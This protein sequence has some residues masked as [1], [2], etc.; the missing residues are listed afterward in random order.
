M[1]AETR[2]GVC[3]VDSMKAKLRDEARRSVDAL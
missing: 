1:A 3:S 2:Q